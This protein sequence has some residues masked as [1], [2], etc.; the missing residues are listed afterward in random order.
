MDAPRSFIFRASSNTSSLASDLNGCCRDTNRAPQLIG[1]VLSRSAPVA[2]S[3]SKSNNV[4]SH[5]M[6][7]FQQN[8]AAR[9]ILIKTDE[10]QNFHHQTS[11]DQFL[12]SNLDSRS[13][14]TETK[15]FTSQGVTNMKSHIKTFYHENLAGRST[16][17]EIDE[18]QNFW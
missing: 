14:M 4:R 1:V 7:F 9:S 11:R 18:Q 17:N 8:L 13:K 16:S 6:T 5:V 15:I 10:Q 2:T 3:E 12:D